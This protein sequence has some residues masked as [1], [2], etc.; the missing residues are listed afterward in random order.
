MNNLEKEEFSSLTNAANTSIYSLF[1][2]SHFHLKKKKKA[3]FIYKKKN[4]VSTDFL[5]HEKGTKKE[6]NIKVCK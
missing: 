2:Y 6:V 1:L 3:F 5:L 4:T